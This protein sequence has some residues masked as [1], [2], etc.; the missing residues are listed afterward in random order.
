MIK[1]HCKHNGYFYYTQEVY[2]DISI[3]YYNKLVKN[4]LY[5]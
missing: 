3:I 2:K 1:R 5:Q 4:M